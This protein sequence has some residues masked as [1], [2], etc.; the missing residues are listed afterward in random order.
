MKAQHMQI[1]LSDKRTKNLQA[2][3]L[4]GVLHLFESPL[5]FQTRLYTQPNDSY[6]V[7]LLKKL[8]FRSSQYCV[9]VGY[10]DN[11]IL[12]YY[13]SS[14]QSLQ[15]SKGWHSF[16]CC[17]RVHPMLQCTFQFCYASGKGFDNL[18]IK[19]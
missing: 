6:T 9:T 1:F 8:A 16:D 3:V 13:P 7:N 18:D 11:G 14:Y 12:L 19:N 2:F 10:Q 5:Q 4:N 17:K 15:Q